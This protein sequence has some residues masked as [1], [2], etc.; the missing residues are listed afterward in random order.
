M[1]PT[2]TPSTPT[3]PFSALNLFPTAQQG[4]A[5]VIDDP[6]QPRQS[7]SDPAAAA[8]PPTQ[9]MTYFYW[10]QQ[11]GAKV[12]FTVPAGQA[13]RANIAGVYGPYKPAP[14]IGVTE[15]FPSQPQIPPV[16]ITDGS[17]F[18]TFAQAQTL[19]AA[20]GGVVVP[21]GVPTATYN[22][23]PTE[24][25][26]IYAVRL[27]NGKTVNVGQEL[28]RVPADANGNSAPGKWS[29]DPSGDP[30]WV[31]AVPTTA[32]ITAVPQRELTATE[33]VIS[34][35]IMGITYWLVGNTANGYSATPPADGG[36][37][38]S[39][40]RAMLTAVYNGLVADQL[41]KGAS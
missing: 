38:T 37:F 1:I 4:D 7:W 18:S 41:I 16:P 29:V 6:T 34:Q 23:G 31:A 20:L 13:A 15:T 8:L 11:T 35:D 5:G 27:P 28:M 24:L 14:P 39:A 40:D 17:I 19:A 3:Y 33:S 36:G 2:S 32:P 12:S 21:G 30:A 25:R 22:Y 10:N 26:Q 9:P